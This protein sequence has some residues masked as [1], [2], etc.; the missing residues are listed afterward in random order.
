LQIALARASCDIT[1]MSDKASPEPE[2][3]KKL[4]TLTRQ[5]L[6]VPKEEIDRRDAVWRKAKAMKRGLK[7]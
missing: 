3:W 7:K 1:G 6:A 5:V 2:T 4:R